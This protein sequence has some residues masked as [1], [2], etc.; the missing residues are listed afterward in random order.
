MEGSSRDDHIQRDLPTKESHSFLATI[1]AAQVGLLSSYLSDLVEPVIDLF[2]STGLA[3]NTRA[4]SFL[5][6]LLRHAF[7]RFMRALPRVFFYKSCAQSTRAE[8]K[9]VTIFV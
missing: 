2:L 3:P 4:T 7:Y 5:V 8:G 6:T 9:S 1:A